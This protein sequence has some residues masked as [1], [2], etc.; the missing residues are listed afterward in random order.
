AEV[1]KK[2][3]NCPL[4]IHGFRDILSF[5]ARDKLAKAHEAIN[6]PSEINESA[7]PASEYAYNQTLGRLTP[8][9]TPIQSITTTKEGKFMNEVQNMKGSRPRT[10]RPFEQSSSRSTAKKLPAALPPAL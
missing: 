7:L 6:N 10:Y 1:Q 8:C 3:I 9:P 2:K 5:M 4:S